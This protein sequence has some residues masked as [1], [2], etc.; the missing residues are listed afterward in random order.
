MKILMDQKKK[1]TTF[2]FTVLD[3]IISQ[4][5]ENIQENY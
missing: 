2:S 1:K 3:K 4:G 5:K